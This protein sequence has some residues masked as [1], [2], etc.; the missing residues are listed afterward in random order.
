MKIFSAILITLLL[1]IQT[2]IVGAQIDEGINQFQTSCLNSEPS[3]FENLEGFIMPLMKSDK[4]N[5]VF[6]DLK[7]LSDTSEIFLWPH[8][9][10]SLSLYASSLLF[11]S[12]VNC[13]YE[14]IKYGQKYHNGFTTGMTYS[15][16]LG[17]D[18][19]LGAHLAYT[20]LIGRTSNLFE[21][22][23]GG[24]FN[25]FKSEFFSFVPVIS[26]GYRYQ[27]PGKRSFFRIGLSTA[28]LGIGFGFII[29]SKKST[30]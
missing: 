14:W 7:Y 26:L 10:S 20:L 16:A 24:V 18:N 30:I 21:M 28:G 23:L 17:E 12:V 25:I 5:P 27:P 8:S 2:M 29:A 1:S 11:A 22:K 4:E 13:S 6:L 9:S 3:V 19:D 15:R